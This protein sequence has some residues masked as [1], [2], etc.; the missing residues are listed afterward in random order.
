[1]LE[2]CVQ[3]FQAAERGHLQ[4][5][6][7]RLLAL[8][9]ARELRRE[10]SQCRSRDSGDRGN[11]QQESRLH[12]LISA[13]ASLDTEPH[14]FHPTVERLPA[15]PKRCRRLRYDAVGANECGLDPRALLGVDIARRSRTTRRASS[16]RGWAQHF[17]GETQV[18]GRDLI[19]RGDHRGALHSVP[20]LAHVARERRTLRAPRAR[21][22]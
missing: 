13:R 9:F 21:W 15:H 6:S 14:A 2:D 1:M 11:D 3:E 19:A 5:A 12:G 10:P 22:P 17:F 16:Q 20:E 7:L 4:G 18:L 8:P